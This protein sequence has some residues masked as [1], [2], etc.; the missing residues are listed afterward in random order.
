M[1][2]IIQDGWSIFFEYKEGIFLFLITMLGFGFFSTNYIHDFGTDIGLSWLATFSIGSVA[3]CL[4]SYALVVLSHHWPLLLIPGSYAILCFS[5]FILSKEIYTGKIKIVYDLRVFI[6]VTALFLLLLVRLAFLKQIILPP[7]SDSP[8]HYQIV[9]GFLHPEISGTSKLSLNTITSDYYHFGF[10][11]LAAWLAAIARIEPENA[12]SLLGQLLLVI[13]PVSI[14]FLVR[15]LI[16]DLNG[17]LFAGLL[18]TIGWYMPAFAVNWGKF[19]ALGSLAVLPAVVAIIVLGSRGKSKTFGMFIWGCA[20]VL[21]TTLIHTRSIVCITLVGISL[22]LAKKLPI[23]DKL[24]FIQSIRYSLLFVIS[25][26]PLKQFLVQYYGVLPA[27]VIFL[28]LLPFAFQVFPRLSV[29]VFLFTSGIWLVGIVPALINTNFRTLLDKQFIA[30]MLYI[31]FSVLGGA[32]IAG[33]MRSLPLKGVWRWVAMAVLIGS[34]IPNILKNGA[35]YPDPCCNYFKTDDQLA[36]RWIQE[37]VTDHDLVLISAF[38]NSGQTLGTDAG[39]WIY[40]LLGRFTNKLPFNTNWNAWFE[41]EHP[42]PLGSGKIYI[43]AGDALY[44]FSDS[45][46]AQENKSKIV[47]DAGKTKIYQ[48][49]RCQK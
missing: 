19:P 43:Y 49:T 20:L 31:P 8:V 3:L 4:I 46:P 34:M 14:I 45:L 17:A 41:A 47:F 48:I 26:W 30:M 33:M 2:T 15:V 9:L 11:S 39:I 24:G 28:I 22:F 13:A 32:G 29:G 12:I 38:D 18:A 10:H 7:Y 40:P 27:A 6:G 23:G 5:I 44:S 1:L 25:L 42:C 16:D 36:F 35:I 21:G 37:K